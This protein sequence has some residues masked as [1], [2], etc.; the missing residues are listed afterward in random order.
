MSSI[1]R[2]KLLVVLLPIVSVT[3]AFC[4]VELLRE[5]PMPS[6]PPGPAAHA[7]NRRMEQKQRLVYEL[8][9]GRRGFFEVAAIF[10]RLNDEYP[11]LPLHPDFRGDSEE[12]R[13]CRQV[14]CW[15]DA[16]MH[17]QS[18][19]QAKIEEVLARFE[20]ELSEHKRRYGAVCLTDAATQ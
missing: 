13:I 18:Y 6:L 11:K 10:R 2:L 14:I 3:A 19:P 9:N 5:E 8:L 20:R 12:E 17:M 15:V 7:L 1:A 4:Q 16:T